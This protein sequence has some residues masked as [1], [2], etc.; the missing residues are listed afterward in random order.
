MSCPFSRINFN[1]LFEI[2]FNSNLCLKNHKQYQTRKL[3]TKKL[4]KLQELN[5]NKNPKYAKS[6]PNANI[7]DP[8]NFNYYE[9]HEN[10]KLI[11]SLKSNKSEKFSI[12]HSNICSLQGN[13]DNLRYC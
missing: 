13:F 1:E 11:Y 6:D 7:T 5:F 9:T 12:F 2:S 10:H 4:L 8:V 3:S